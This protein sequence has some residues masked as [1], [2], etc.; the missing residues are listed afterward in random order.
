MS[1]AEQSLTD[2]ITYTDLYRRWEESNW[3]AYAIDFSEDKAGW[4]GLSDIQRRSALWTYSMF[5]YG[6]DS[7]TDNLSPYI[8]AAPKEEQKYF[9]AT[10][11]VDEARHAV[12]FHRF[13]K[14]VIGA[15]DDIASGLAFTEAQLGWGYRK[16]FGRL[17]RMA[18]ELR[19]DRSLPKFAQA[20]T[21][22]HLIV[23]ATLAQPGQHYIEDFFV[24]QGT[25]PGFAQGMQNVSRDEQRHIGF[26]VKVL[27][28]LVAESDECKAAID[29]ILREVMPWTVGVFMPPNGDREYTRCYGFEMEDI[30]AFGMKA[31]EAKWRAIGY[32][33]DEM[34]PGAFPFDFSLP[35]E[36]RAARS[37]EMM[38]AGVIGPP[39]ENPS[40]DPKIQEMYFDVIARSA[41]AKAVNGHR[42]TIDWRFSD[43]ESW[44]LTLDNGST[45]AA[46]GASPDPDVTIESSWRDWIQMSAG[47]LHPARALASRRIRLHG[48][49]TKLFRFMKVFPA[50][51]R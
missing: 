37:I 16:V 11:Q 20:I 24:R 27:A 4:A 48:G 2:K 32:P 13:F 45:A 12:F 44:H 21:L 40:T 29:E 15:G 47:E 43:A 14:E 36:E 17:D 35:P 18:D 7:V 39:N 8:D 22:Y 41:D 33:M 1:V 51:G 30:F 10:Q 19:R 28:E 31:L 49:P 38:M 3:S 42:F 50:R 5:F 25:M 23:E 26:G 34:P 6:E 9:L 46:P